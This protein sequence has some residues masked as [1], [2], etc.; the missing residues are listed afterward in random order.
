MLIHT[1]TGEMWIGIDMWSSYADNKHM[2]ADER[3][4]DRQAVT[5]YGDTV[6]FNVMSTVPMLSETPIKERC[7]V[8][9][10]ETFV[11]RCCRK[12]LKPNEV[13]LHAFLIQRRERWPLGVFYHE[14]RKTFQTTLWSLT[15]RDDRY[16]IESPQGAH[17]HKVYFRTRKHL[18]TVAK[19]LERTGQRMVVIRPADDAAKI[20]LDLNDTLAGMPYW[21]LRDFFRNLSIFVSVSARTLEHCLCVPTKRAQAIFEA[22]LAEQF[23]EPN[24]EY[25][26]EDLRFQ[27]ATKGISLTQART[28]RRMNRATID[29]LVANVWKR[30]LEVNAD[31]RF[32]MRFAML[33]IFGSVMDEQAQ[34]FGDLDVVFRLD[35]KPSWE[36]RRGSRDIEQFHVQ[37]FPQDDT[38]D[39]FRGIH[40]R[41]LQHLRGRQGR[42]SVHDEDDLRRLEEKHSVPYRLLFGKRMARQ[43]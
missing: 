4:W 28:M 2:P 29:K 21:V 33:G 5:R 23:I 12:A 41:P 17:A 11:R 27:L 42:I 32:V 6:V 38:W 1:A 15:T 30:A 39:R 14:S 3:Q 36:E 9:T 43:W 31:D 24:P 18:T 34:D 40:N 16:P 13:V 20:D 8:S 35:Y 25:G 22:L 10:A 37:H 7:S 26:P 19:A